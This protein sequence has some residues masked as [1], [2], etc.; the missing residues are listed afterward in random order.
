MILDRPGNT[1]SKILKMRQHWSGLILQLLSFRWTIPRL[2]RAR[3][4]AGHAGLE[5]ARTGGTTSSSVSLI[6]HAAE[7]GL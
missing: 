2:L 6:S 3:M 5:T 7:F 4:S 1:L